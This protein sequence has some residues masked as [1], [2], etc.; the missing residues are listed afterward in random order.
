MKTWQH[1]REQICKITAQVMTTAFG[2][3][4]GHLALVLNDAEY[5]TA[6]G[7]ETARPDRLASPPHVHPEITATTNQHGRAQ[8]EASQRHKFTAYYLQEATD[9]AIVDR[10]VKEG[11][12]QHIESLN[13][14]YTAYTNKTI[15]LILHHIKTE[16]VQITNKDKTDAKGT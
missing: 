5:C 14:K 4:H 13:N 9:E 12:D 6:T 2:G 7:N 10:I 11:I 3:K 16:W 8:L 1:L 15:K